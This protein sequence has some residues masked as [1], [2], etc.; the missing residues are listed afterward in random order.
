MTQT[1]TEK[2]DLAL[3]RDAENIETLCFN[4][5]FF[6]LELELAL[7]LY[8]QLLSIRLGGTSMR[9]NRSFCVNE[10]FLRGEAT[11]N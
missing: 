7:E 9:I 10:R 8:Y 11:E 2:R 3:L 1:D 6:E 5:S 4:Y